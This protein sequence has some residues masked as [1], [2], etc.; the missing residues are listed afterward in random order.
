MVLLINRIIW[1]KWKCAV[2]GELFPFCLGLR[3]GEPN[4][5]K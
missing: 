3:E 2:Q 5:N 1:E 4:F